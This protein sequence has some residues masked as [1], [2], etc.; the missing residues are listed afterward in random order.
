MFIQK[1]K[2]IVNK[3]N[4]IK[5]VKLKKDVVSRNLAQI[6]SMFDN[7]RKDLRREAEL[8]NFSKEQIKMRMKDIEERKFDGLKI[9]DEAKIL[10]EVFNPKKIM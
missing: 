5:F 7:C 8:K 3:D 10:N 4:I 2:K 9:L 1:R 6:Q